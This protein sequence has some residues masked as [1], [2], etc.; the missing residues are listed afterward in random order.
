MNMEDYLDV[1]GDMIDQGWSIPLSGGK[2]AVDS[3]KVK[4]LLEDIRLHMPTEI[5]Q[6]KLI[7]ADR[8]DI[9]AKAKAEAEHII[10]T[11][12]ERARAMVA[13]DEIHRQATLRASEIMEQ[14]Q[15]KSRE[16]RR[17]A[18]DF[19][20]TV[21]K[22]TEECLSGSLNEVKQARTALRIPKKQ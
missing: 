17:A 1:L 12:E 11:A 6:A 16:M 5:R 20:E 19:A 3:A 8:S 10:H 18:T 22:N 14:A 7:V 2:V 21:L 13:Q 9:I 15:T 4:E